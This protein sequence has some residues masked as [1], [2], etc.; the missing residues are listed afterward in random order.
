[1]LWVAG[2]LIWGMMSV[3]SATVGRASLI[4]WR[5][6]MSLRAPLFSL[7]PEETV[8]VAQAAFPNGNVYMRMRDELGLIYDNALFADLF[9]HDGQPAQS[10]AQLAL[11]TIMQFAEGLADR[12]A[13]DAVRDRLAWKYALGLELTDPGFD[14]S[15]LCEFRARLLAGNA[16]YLLFD[17]MLTVLRERGLLKGH[18]RQRTDSTHVLAAIRTLNRLTCVGETLRYALNELAQLAPDWLR[19]QITVDWFD[20]YSQRMEEFRLPKEK[21]DRA[22]LAMQI[23]TDGNRLLRAIEAPDTPAVVRDL[24]AVDVLRQIWAQQYGAADADGLVRWRDEQDLPPGAELIISPYDVEARMSAKRSISWI[25]YKV[26]VTETYPEDGPHLITHIETTEATLPDAQAL[27][28]IHTALQERD[29]L[30][31][32]HLLDAGY[33]DSERLV[34]SQTDYQVNLLGP[35]PADGAWQARSDQGYDVSCF[36]IDWDAQTVTCPAGAQSTAWK[37]TF[38]RHDKEVIHVEFARHSCAACAVR[39]QCTRSKT[40]GREITLRPRERHVALQD[41]RKRQT[42]PEFKAA[43]AARSGIEGTLSQGVRV[44]DLRQARYRGLAKTRLQEAIIA[45]AINLL[46]VIAWLMEAPRA[47]TRQ[48]AFA[49]LA[50]AGISAGHAGWG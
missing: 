20:R 44:C 38:D 27:G 19:A 33:V 12:P 48:S 6:L 3:A 23:G 36:S 21:A 32:E 35:V 1:M 17:A 7:I 40:A 8:R 14:A 42:T 5:F 15:V 2:C 30:M 24:G 47:L 26:H 11:V 34:E 29:L 28:P 43:Y 50:P 39:A 18:Q 16:E 9:P 4:L 22:A 46:R 31:E 25:G 49:R 13:A 37:P 45:T 10:P 41:A